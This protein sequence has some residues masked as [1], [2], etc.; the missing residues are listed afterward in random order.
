MPKYIDVKIRDAHGNIQI[1][2]QLERNVKT[3]IER[4]FQNI[5]RELNDSCM[6]IPTLIKLTN[7]IKEK[8][9]K[10][11]QTQ[12]NNTK[13]VVRSKKY[14]LWPYYRVILKKY[15]LKFENEIIKREDEIKKYY[16]LDKN[17]NNFLPSTSNSNVRT[18]SNEYE[19]PPYKKKITKNIRKTNPIMIKYYSKHTR[20]AEDARRDAYRNRLFNKRKIIPKTKKNYNKQKYTKRKYTTKPK[21]HY[22]SSVL[23]EN[24]YAIDNTDQNKLSDILNEKTRSDNKINIEDYED[25]Y[26]DT[27]NKETR[28]DD[29]DAINNI[30]DYKHLYDE[31][32]LKEDEN[33]GTNNNQINVEYKTLT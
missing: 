25:L 7:E 5:N 29:D 3:Q 12:N 23:N 19:S 9:F 15:L 30:E 20:K 4:L 28:T 10:I 17:K 8:I 6:C 33:N 32:T 16:H 2:K 27:L 31:D 24:V 26:N 22:L 11:S 1:I 13:I 18:Y 14:N 21:Q